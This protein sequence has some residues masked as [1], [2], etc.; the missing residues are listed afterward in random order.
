MFPDWRL[1]R[2]LKRKAEQGV[3][4]YV[5]VYKEVGQVAGFRIAWLT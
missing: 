2:L 4:I 3:R 5:M 1:D